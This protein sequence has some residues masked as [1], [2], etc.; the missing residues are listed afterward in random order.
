[1]KEKLEFKVSMKRLHV[2]EAALADLEGRWD[3]EGHHAGA[4]ELR[5]MVEEMRWIMVNAM[6]AYEV[7]P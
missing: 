7:E 2:L 6:P 5:A 3:G 1:M 4:E